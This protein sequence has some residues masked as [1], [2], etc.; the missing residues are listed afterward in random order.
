M[1]TYNSKWIQNMVVLVVKGHEKKKN[2]ND[3]K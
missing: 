2:L 3:E 1:L